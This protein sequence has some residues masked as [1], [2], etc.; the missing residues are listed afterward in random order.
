MFINFASKNLRMQIRIK[1]RRKFLC[2]GEFWLT[3]KAVVSQ[4]SGLAE[5]Q[6]QWQDGVREEMV[7]PAHAC[8]ALQLWTQAPTMSTP[9]SEWVLGNP[10][11]KEPKKTDFM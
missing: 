9:G 6:W 10:A 7:F 1:G 8:N 11:L 2:F 5:W 4:L 3:P